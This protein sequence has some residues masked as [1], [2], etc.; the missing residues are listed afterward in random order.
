MDC[1]FCKIIAGEIPARKIY[2]TDHIIVIRDIN[3]EAPVH[4]LIIPKK[5]IK[6]L[7]DL[8][9]IEMA[10]DILISAKKIA[11]IEGVEKSGYRLISNTGRNGGQLIPHLHFH[12][13]GGKKLGP[14]LVQE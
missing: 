5:H 4:D 6:D 8:D 11:K 2:E 3:P 13:L 14:K 9:D 12:L 10:A 7:N 1:I